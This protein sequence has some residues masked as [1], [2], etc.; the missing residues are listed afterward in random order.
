[1]TVPA[2]KYQRILVPLDG[3]ETAEFAIPYAADLA[4]H[5]NAQLILL[6][7]S[8]EANGNGQQHQ[9]EIEHTL[10]TSGIRV[11][12]RVLDN[13]TSPKVIYNFLETERINLIVMS[14][15][16]H[17]S[18]MR[19]LFGSNIE[20]ALN[21]LPVPIMLIRPIYHTI[22]VPLDGSKWSESA[23]PKATELA[24]TH[25]AELVLLHIYQSP[26]SSYADQV[27]LAG[28]QEMADQ[29]YAQMREQLVSLRNR[30]RQEGLRAREQLIR[31]TN[32]AQ[33][34]CD[35][36][37]AEEGITMIVMSTHGR[38][39]LSR[40]LLGSVAQKVMKETR[41]PV[42]LVHPDKS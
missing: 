7:V 4:R 17:T 10:R 3:S 11:Q 25:H 20:K 34:I 39:G 31:G 27:A 15:Q 8:L 14:V 42:T 40:W 6:T 28:Q 38:T 24:R 29:A 18:M 9:A 33:A 19:W 35:F 16:G 37:E 26:V 21:D 41:Y 22:V 23:I 1:M 32:P 2:P 13:R 12:L 30:L 5:H 36:V